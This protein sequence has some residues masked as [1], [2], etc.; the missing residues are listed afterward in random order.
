[1]GTTVCNTGK[2]YRKE[3]YRMQRKYEVT[4]GC[5]ADPGNCDGNTCTS[6]YCNTEKN[7]DSDPN[8]TPWGW[9]IAIIVVVT[10]CTINKCMKEREMWKLEAAY[11]KAKKAGKT[12]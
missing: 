3:E 1:M 4:G 8:K 2:C 5:C 9:I 12:I 11:N 6:P 7:N 10:L